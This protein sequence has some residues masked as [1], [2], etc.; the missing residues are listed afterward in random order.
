MKIHLISDHPDLP[1][2]EVSVDELPVVLGRSNGCD[3]RILD[4]MLSRQQCELTFHNNSVRVRDLE[5]TNGTIVNSA[6]VNDAPLYPGDIITI[7]MANYVVSYYDDE[8]QEDFE[9]SYFSENSI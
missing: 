3:I 7:G 9:E 6:Q 8:G 5:S 4:P 1:D 2:I